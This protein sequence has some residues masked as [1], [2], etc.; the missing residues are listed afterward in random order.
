MTLFLCC[1]GFFILLSKTYFR[2]SLRYY[3][4]QTFPYLLAQ[5]L[6]L[7]AFCCSLFIT[8]TQRSSIARCLMTVSYNL[9]EFLRLR[10]PWKFRYLSGLLQG[11]GEERETDSRSGGLVGRGTFICSLQKKRKPLRRYLLT[12]SPGRVTIRGIYKR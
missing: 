3:I 10:E 1:L 6:S 12:L 8:L 9:E 2:G 5:L 11:E 4:P 7:S